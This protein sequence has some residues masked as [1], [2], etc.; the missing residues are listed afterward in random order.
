V[1]ELR[2]STRN[3]NK[4]LDHL[5]EG[6]EGATPI[7]PLVHFSKFGKTTFNIDV[8]ERNAVMEAVLRQQPFDLAGANASVANIW[9]RYQD[10]VELFPDDIKSDNQA[11]LCFTDWL[12][13]RVVLVEIG[14]TDQD[15]ALEIFETMNDRGLRLSNTDMLKGF[16]LARMGEPAA[17]E[18]ANERWRRRVGELTDA[19]KNADA[20]FIKTWLRG[21]YA[22]TI[23]DRKKDASPRDFD[24]IGT[25]FHKWVRDNA[26]RIGLRKASE[27]Q[28]LVSKDFERLSRRYL[29]LL[30]ASTSLIPGFEAVYYNAIN[31][32]TL[33]FLP[34][35]AAVTPDDDDEAFQSKTHLISNYLDLMI[36]RRMVNYRN[37]GYSTLVYTMFNLAKDLRDKSGDEVRDVLADRVA[38]I[39]ESF[40]GVRTFALTQRNRAHIRY[41][42]ARMTAWVEGHCGKAQTF[43]Q[44]VDR[45]RK[46]PFEVEH[47]WANHHHR[48]TQEFPNPYDF[49]NFR[50]RFGGL[51]LLP[52]SFNASYGDKSYEE[53]LPHYFSQNLLAA[54]LSPLAYENNPA[55]AAFRQ[56]TGLPFRA[57]EGSFEKSDF[58][59]RQDLYRRICD[60][61]WS[62]DALG[63]GGGTATAALSAEAKR[64]FY[65]VELAHLIEAGFLAPGTKMLGSRSGKQY[66]ATITADGRVQIPDGTIHRSPSAAADHLTQF[67]TNGWEFWRIDSPSDQR[68]LSEIRSAYLGSAGHPSEV[69][70]ASAAVDPEDRR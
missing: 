54:S 14:T 3:Q 50:N 1:S 29:S 53:K 45:E 68:T 15:M 34:I 22:D 57:Y 8:D 16:L 19:E 63:L 4:H 2:T 40:D 58:E 61:V 17:V 6:V 65:G 42:L 36:V 28:T 38:G 27:F 30:T 24:L 23:R 48:H 44:Y 18:S 25:A 47:L 32:F 20:E 56:S 69:D 70:S 52:K 35:V 43:P 62:P 31:G 21:K 13:E 41:L 64:A 37:F 60:Q 5:L 11:L 66:S 10:I 46:D 33:Q 12:L 51:V 59:E 9:A 7:G 39:P 55:F 26:E 67:S 49:E